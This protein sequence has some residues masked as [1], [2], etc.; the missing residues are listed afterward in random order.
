MTGRT[1]QGARREERYP[2]G[3]P[4]QVA[5]QIASGETRA[6]R[7]TC[8]DVSPHGACIECSEPLAARS[9]L[10]LKAPGYGLMGNASVRYCRRKG[11]KY[12][13]GLEFSW[14]AALAEEGRKHALRETEQ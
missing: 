14:A 2:L 1:S 7:A 12:H 11:L 13:I 3:C 6:A 8:V 10:Y 9:T 5:W 4:V